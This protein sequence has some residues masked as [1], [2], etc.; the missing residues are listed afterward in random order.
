MI[1]KDYT[2]RLMM[3]ASFATRCHI[4]SVSVGQRHQQD[5]TFYQ[6]DAMQPFSNI[7]LYQIHPKIFYLNHHRRNFSAYL[8]SA[9]FD[10]VKKLNAIFLQN[11]VIC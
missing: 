5:M 2:F 6:N 7:V 11:K 8:L 10:H 4:H 9:T 3:L 1:Q